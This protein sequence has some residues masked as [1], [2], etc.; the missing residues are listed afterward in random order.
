MNAG[1][2]SPLAWPRKG[3]HRPKDSTPDTSDVEVIPC[4]KQ[5]LV[6]SSGQRLPSDQK[7]IL[8]RL[9]ANLGFWLQSASR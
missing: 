4:A 6:D 1:D 5:S 3:L 9:V 7:P 8:H 2:D